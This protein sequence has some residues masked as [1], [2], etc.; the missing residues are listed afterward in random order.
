MGQQVLSRTISGKQG[1]NT[2]SLETSDLKNGVYLYTIQS[3]EKRLT[4]KLI[5][6]H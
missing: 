2:Y 4:K 3:G 1:K 5:V 6:Q